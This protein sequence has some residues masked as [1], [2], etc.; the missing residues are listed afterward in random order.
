MSASVEECVALS[1]Q[2]CTNACAGYTRRTAMDTP[3]SAKAR[4]MS[5][6]AIVGTGM[7]IFATGVLVLLLGF[8]QF[9]RHHAGAATTLLLIGAVL[10]VG[11]G[12]FAMMAR[13]RK[14]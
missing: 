12:A 7:S 3:P 14:D 5:A 9:L 11:G 10:A 4:G 13:S 1:R 8:A 2:D 6:K